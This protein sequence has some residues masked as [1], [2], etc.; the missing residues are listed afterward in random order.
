VLQSLIR[1]RQRLAVDLDAI[2]D[3]LRYIE[4]DL[5][6]DPAY[7]P[8]HDAIRKALAEV[9]K[10]AQSEAPR[11]LDAAHTANAVFVPAEF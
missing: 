10:L 11:T 9:E 4:S 3:T 7:A 6:G 5:G 2:G 8:L 1:S